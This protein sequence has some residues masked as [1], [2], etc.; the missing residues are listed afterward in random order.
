MIEYKCDICG[1]KMARWVN[2]TITPDAINQDMNIYD[3]LNFRCKRQICENC[4]SNITKN[5][6]REVSKKYGYSFDI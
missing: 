5:A 4:M 3:L 6:L 1:Q 2:I